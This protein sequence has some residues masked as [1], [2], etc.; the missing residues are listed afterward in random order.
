MPSDASGVVEG[1]EVEF[2][3]VYFGMSWSVRVS[4]Q[5]SDGLGSEILV[6]ICVGH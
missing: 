2:I 5:T 4:M 1:L 6:V 3:N